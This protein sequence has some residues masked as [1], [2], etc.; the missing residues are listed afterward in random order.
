MVILVDKPAQT[1]KADSFMLPLTSSG[2][3]LFTDGEELRKAFEESGLKDY[4]TV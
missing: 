4:G 2:N 1:L 3:V